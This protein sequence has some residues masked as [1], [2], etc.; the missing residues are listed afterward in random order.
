MTGWWRSLERLL[1]ADPR[2]VGCDGAIAVLHVY[3]ELLAARIDAAEQFP[4]VAT[5]LAACASCAEDTR[6]LLAA[7]EDDELHV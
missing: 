1:A 6:G 3:V 2:D 5:H 7:V 4:G